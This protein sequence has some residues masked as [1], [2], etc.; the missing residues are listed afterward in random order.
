MI[1]PPP[2]STL[3]PYTTLFRSSSGWAVNASNNTDGMGRVHLVLNAFSTSAMSGQGTFINLKFNVIGAPNS[4]TTLKWHSFNFN[5]ATPTDPVDS[6]VDGTFTVAAPSASAV[7]LSG[8][9]LTP[10]GEPVGGTT[11]TVLGGAAPVRAITDSQGFYRVYG[12]PAGGFYTVTPSRAN[13]VFA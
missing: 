12:L 4:S 11:V 1:R 2:R 9:I 10:T 13:F 6:D 5:E 7:M 3:F 8:Q